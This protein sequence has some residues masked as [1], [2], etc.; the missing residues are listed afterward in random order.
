MGVPNSTLHYPLGFAQ[1]PPLLTYICGPKAQLGVGGH[2]IFLRIFYLGSLCSL[3][4]LFCDGLI[5]SI[6]KSWTCEG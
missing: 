4:L 2:F 6:K 3:N 1:S 5:K